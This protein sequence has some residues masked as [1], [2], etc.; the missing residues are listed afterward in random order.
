MR[1]VLLLLA[2][3]AALV[4]PASV[5]AAPARCS[6]SITP[7]V[8]SATDVYRI[9][10]TNVPSDPNISVEANVIVRNAAARTGSIYFAFLIP[11]VTEFFIDHNVSYEGEEPGSLAPGRYMV[12]VETPHIKGPTACHAIGWFTVA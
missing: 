8:G 2:L 10:A 12:T 7:S 9:L 3:A 1:R 5:T 6:V 11:G 4:A